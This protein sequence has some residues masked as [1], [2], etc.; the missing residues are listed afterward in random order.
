VQP[1]VSAPKSQR[2]CIVTG[3][4]HDRSGLLRFVV[5]PN[6]ELVADLAS[7]LPGRG[8]WLT[9]RRDILERA[10]SR[11]LFARS[12]HR[13]IMTPPGLADRI[14]ALLVQRC[15]EMIGLARRAGVAVAGFEKAREAVRM[16]KVGLLFLALDGAGGGRR[17]I[18][19]LGR[20]LPI[21]IVLT[22]TEMGT[23]FGRDHVVNIAIGD[24]GLTGRLITA[25]EKI[26][27]FRLGAVIDRAELASGRPVWQHGGIE[28]R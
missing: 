14:E 1:E 27:G 11:R 9:P 19:A 18:C 22:A 23:I 26:A 4:L 10:I 25:A 15:F 12:A 28:S 6:D 3:E 21:A 8:L 2:R 20:G 16:G 7:R 24:S 5:G 13:A 17:K